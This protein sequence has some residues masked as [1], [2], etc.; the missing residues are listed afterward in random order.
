MPLIN[1][2]ILKNNFRGFAEKMSLE[3]NDVSIPLNLLDMP[4]ALEIEN[5]DFYETIHPFC[6]GFENRVVSRIPLT[7]NSTIY[8]QLPLI[9]VD[10][11]HFIARPPDFNKTFIITNTAVIKYDF[12][13][14]QNHD[15]R[16][17][18]K[19]YEVNDFSDIAMLESDATLYMLADEAEGVANYISDVLKDRCLVMFDGMNY[20]A[21]KHYFT[22]TWLKITA[23]QYE[24]HP[25]KSI[26]ENSVN[27]IKTFGG[28]ITTISSQPSTRYI[29]P[30]VKYNFCPYKT[31]PDKPMNCKVCKKR[32]EGYNFDCEPYHVSDFHYLKS[33]IESK[34]ETPDGFFTSSPFYANKSKEEAIMYWIYPYKR[35][36]V[37]MTFDSNWTKDKD[38]FETIRTELALQLLTGNG[39]AYVLNLAH[40]TCTINGQV[41]ESILQLAGMYGLYM[42]SQ[43]TIAKKTSTDSGD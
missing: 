30:V 18:T 29:S 3:N 31:N 16:V 9:G 10:G 21:L 32:E 37:K 4:P 35:W 20:S 22:R 25:S 39:Y 15:I 43:K 6:E 34:Y 17:Y 13:D 14:K 11:S 8:N 40:S 38:I 2:T 12:S 36:F 7:Q 24:N 19:V 23:E 41:R 28:I 5:S 26:Y 1:F 27:T 42:P 33:F